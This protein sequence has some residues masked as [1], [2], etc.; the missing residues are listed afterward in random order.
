M[1]GFLQSSSIS[2]VKVDSVNVF[3]S[4]LPLNSDHEIIYS[5]G[6]N[7]AICHTQLTAFEYVKI[8]QLQLPLQPLT[9][10]QP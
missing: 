8:V 3:T 10:F 4:L 5:G 6:Y 2:V 9:L 1:L 7:R